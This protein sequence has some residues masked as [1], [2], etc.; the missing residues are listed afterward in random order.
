M[1]TLRRVCDENISKD[2]PTERARFGA[3]ENARFEPHRKFDFQK[4]RRKLTDGSIS[5][6]VRKHRLTTPLGESESD[7]W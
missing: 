3:E 5:F 2:R 6:F 4:K 7:R 1:Y